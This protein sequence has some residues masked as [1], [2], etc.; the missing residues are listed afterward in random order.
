MKL[1]TKNF[2]KNLL[3][4]LPPVLFLSYYPVISLGASDTTNFELS[5]PEIWLIIFAISLIPLIKNLFHFYKFKNLAIISILPIYLSLSALWSDNPL[6][7]VLTA[8]IF[9]LLVVAALGIVYLFK[10]DKTLQDKILKSLLFSAVFFSLF[11]WVQ[12][13]LDLAGVPRDYSLL[14]RGCVSTVLGFPHPSGFATEPQ[15][16]GG[17]LIAPALLCFYRRQSQKQG[18]KYTLLAVFLTATLF[19]TLSRGAIFAF[20]AGL[21]LLQILTK[22][23]KFLRALFACAIAFI[24]ALSAQGI[25]ASL[26]PTSDTFFSGITKSIHQVSL[27]LIDLR[28]T[29]PQQDA[30]STPVT[31]STSKFSGYIAESTDIRLSLNS[32][33]IST[34][35]SSPRYILVGT[36]LGSAGLAMHALHSD[37]LGPKEIVQN[38][39]LSLLLETGLLGYALIIATALFL[40]HRTFATLKRSPLFLATIF[41]FGLT[42]LFFSGLPNALHI[43]LFPLLFISFS[44]N[45]LSVE[46]IV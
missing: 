10:N 33:A 45:N 31:Q 5:I 30:S 3:L 35:A 13:V 27:G 16:M 21:I 34:W 41:A 37:L 43:Y 25:F 29:T 44:K 24:F 28:P 9:W 15:F 36:G 8:G 14:C 2:S 20:V 19:L 6:R 38:E 46:Q 17:L 4:I 11:C 40:V 18:Q 23:K 7:A 26:S 42:L 12:C 22:N 1:F 39:Y 32:L